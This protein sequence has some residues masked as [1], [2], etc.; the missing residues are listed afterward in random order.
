MAGKES[1][2]PLKALITF[3]SVLSLLLLTGSAVL[4]AGA[5]VKWVPDGIPMTRAAGDDVD[6]LVVPDGSGGAIVVWENASDRIRAQHVDINGNLQWGN[7]GL[8]VFG[9]ISGTVFGYD[10]IADGSGGAFVVCDEA[11]GKIHGQHLDQNGNRLWGVNG[12]TLHSG[13]ADSWYPRLCS[14][15]SGGIIAAWENR[16]NPTSAYDILAQRVDNTGTA[17][18]NAVPGGGAVVYSSSGEQTNVQIAAGTSGDAIIAWQDERSGN[19]YVYAQRMN[20]TGN[21]QWI[22]NGV[23]IGEGGWSE[24]YTRDIAPDGVG[25]AVIGWEYPGGA[26]TSSDIYA[27]RVNSAGM[28]QWTAGGVAV[29]SNDAAQWRP[30]VVSNGAQGAF[31]AWDDYRNNET[32]V[33]CQNVNSDG[34][35]YWM[36]NGFQVTVQ[37]EAQREVRAAS[38]G[39]GGVMLAWMDARHGYGYEVYAQ[40]LNNVGNEYWTSTGVRVCSRENGECA[41]A[42]ANTA[43]G[44]AII[45]WI[46]RRNTPSTGYDIYAQRVMTTGGPLPTTWYFAEGTTRAGFDEYIS[47]E[48]ANAASS[49]VRITYMLEGGAT[50]EQTLSVPGRSRATVNVNAFLG[51]EVDNSAQV[52]TTNNVP[53]VAER[54]M[55]FN[56]NGVWMGGHDVVGVNQTRQDWYFAEGTTRP[57][58]D[59]YICLQNPGNNAAAV[60][61]TYMLENSQTQTQDLT[62]GAKSRLT[63]PVN[64]V[65]GPGVDNSAQVSSTNGVP[66]VAERPMYFNY[67]DVW[68]GGHCTTGAMNPATTWYFAE[69]TTRPEFDQYI[70]LQ[71][72]EANQADVKITYMM[73]GGQTSEQVIAVPPS[74]RTTVN[75]KQ[76]LGEGVDN[77]AKVETTNGVNIVAERPMYFDYKGMWTGGHDVVGTNAPGDTWYFAEGTTRAGFE[78]WLC[79]QNPNNKTVEALV[80]YMQDDGQNNLDTITLPSTSRVTIWVNDVIYGEHDV[81]IRVESSDGSP[82]IAERPMYFN[83]GVYGWTGGHDVLG[84]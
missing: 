28:N 21:Q 32:D 69:G 22:A 24:Y 49:D 29:C 44:E 81:S 61:I 60:R 16:T 71:N 6:P 82:I 46:D 14:D 40:R 33:Y 31:I 25:G 45:A 73:E 70:C 53:I 80:T 19:P 23:Q 75:V 63:V 26:A 79:L 37:P 5:E 66:I 59:Q 56:Y 50:Q 78:E 35:P 48:N 43:G 52:E 4:L 18:W 39:A 55:Y 8:I 13:S 10:A 30:Q 68:T 84:Y 27:Q 83:Y 65:L 47:I 42:L 7:D 64:A 76:I 74:S 67:N 51:P 72:P 3:I 9:G 77:S 58:F 34:S 12:V 54:P 1:I 57:G 62:I 15:G 11:G 2:C 17:L 38:D 41:P 20:G 36:A